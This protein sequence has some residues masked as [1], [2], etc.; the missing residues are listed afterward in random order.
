MSEFSFLVDGVQTMAA[1]PKMLVMWVVGALLIWLAIEKDFEPALL[2]PMG[3][4]AILV[5]LPLPGVLGNIAVDAAGHTT[6]EGAPGIVTWLFQTGIETS[7][8]F[9]L[10]LFVG[11]G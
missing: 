4:G 6:V 2:L 8:A 5:N 1:N 11:I 3:F 9:P 7:E 10:L